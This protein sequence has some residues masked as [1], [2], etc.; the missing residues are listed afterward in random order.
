M[1]HLM[2]P[3]Y[4]NANNLTLSQEEY[5]QA[6][7]SWRLIQENRAP[8]FLRKRCHDPLFN[9]TTSIGFFCH[10][11]YSR[12]FDIHPHCS[13]LYHNIDLKSQGKCL[14]LMI[15]LALSAFAHSPSPPIMDSSSTSSIAA[16]ASVAPPATNTTATPVLYPSRGSAP[17]V[18]RVHQQGEEE[19]FDETLRQLAMNKAKMG[20][21]SV[22]CKEKIPS[23]NPLISSFSCRWDN[24]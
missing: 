23:S 12:F 4:Y 20:V 8:E 13:S 9:F 21:R 11:F 17:V 10:N 6:M 15:H 3:V 16:T 14:V 22:E 7:T 18:T 2:M 19:R 1:A 5:R 24:G